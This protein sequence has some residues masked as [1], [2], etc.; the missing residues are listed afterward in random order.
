MRPTGQ[1][2]TSQSPLPPFIHSHPEGVILNIKV[3]PRAS[4][5][6]I[7]GVL[8]GELKVRVTAPPVDSAANQA[9]VELLSDYLDCPKSALAILRGQTAKHKVILV[10]GHSVSEIW[11]HLKTVL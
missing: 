9:V 7:D 10:R 2:S 3:Q 11:N 6:G 4:R 8:G 1:A 5:C